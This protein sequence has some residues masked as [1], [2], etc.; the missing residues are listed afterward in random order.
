[1]CANNKETIA[2]VILLHMQKEF[3]SIFQL[4]SL[5]LYNFDLKKLYHELLRRVHPDKNGNNPD[6]T[7][8][9]QNLADAYE[10]MRR[11]REREIEDEEK[12]I[13]LEFN[14]ER[15]RGKERMSL[16]K[17][18][19]KI[20]ERD[21]RSAIITLLNH[22]LMTSVLALFCLRVVRKDSIG[23][24]QQ[25]KKRERSRLRNRMSWRCLRKKWF[26]CE[27]YAIVLSL[28][29]SVILRDMTGID[30]KQKV[31]EKNIKT[32]RRVRQKIK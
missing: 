31:P 6:S 32:Q 18:E 19:R 21:L 7:L 2:K 14:R 13:E 10:S 5:S 16:T 25:W 26:R 12:R 1:M 9:Q 17:K 28:F 15:K 4:S 20:N 24:I 22:I 29:L 3:L 27:K 11:E 8:A 23:K 30:R